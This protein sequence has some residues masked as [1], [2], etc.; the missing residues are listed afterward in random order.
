MAE[1]AARTDERLDRQITAVNETLRRAVKMAVGEHRRERVRRRELDAK[2][3]QL[4]AA[5]VVTE[6][7]L[8]G[9]IRALGQRS[10]GH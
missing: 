9:L 6:E 7:R 5:R 4:A 1:R 8:Q 2:I 10:N 3:G